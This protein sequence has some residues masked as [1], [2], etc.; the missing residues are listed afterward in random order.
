[1]KR[2]TGIVIFTLVFAAGLSAA[3]A[4][5]LSIGGDFFNYKNAFLDIGASCI[6][7]IEN[8]MELNFDANFGISTTNDGTTTKANI[9][10]PFD[11]GLNF[12]FNEQSKMNFLVGTGITPQ[13][14][15]VD[16][17]RF[18]IGPYLKGGIRLKVHEYMRW[19]FEAQQDLLIGAPGWINTTT[20]LRTG[21]LFSFG[22]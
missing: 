18:Y 17:P 21:I 12:I 13:F 19:F 3:P 8:G 7:P 15:N 2:F 4:Y 9:Y 6:I 20:S 5:S 14:L 1:M 16:S 22:S 10:L 11:V